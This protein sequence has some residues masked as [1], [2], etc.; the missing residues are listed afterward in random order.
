VEGLEARSF[1]LSRILDQKMKMPGDLVMEAQV[2]LRQ[3]AAVIPQGPDIDH[4]IRDPDDV[5]VLA[6]AMGGGSRYRRRP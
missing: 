5:E 3:E 4:R 6:Q 2:F 1:E